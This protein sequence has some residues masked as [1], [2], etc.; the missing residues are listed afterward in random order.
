MYD[1][2]SFNFDEQKREKIILK[3]GRYDFVVKNSEPCVYNSG[4]S[5]IKLSLLV[6][7]IT[8]VYDNLIFIQKSA[9]KIKGFMLSIGKNPKRPPENDEIVGC[10]GELIV[11]KEEFEGKSRNT[12]KEYIYEENQQFDEDEDEEIPF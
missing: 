9:W 12:V 11:Q 4:N 10:R 8:M 1:P 3:P 2:N 6:N 7:N 5:G